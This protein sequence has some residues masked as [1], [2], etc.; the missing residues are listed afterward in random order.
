MRRQTGNMDNSYEMKKTIRELVA[1]KTL[2][3]I[4]SIRMKPE[5]R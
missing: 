2:I 3:K 4:E 5:Y 1:M